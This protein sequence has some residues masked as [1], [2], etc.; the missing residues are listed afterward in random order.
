MS[1]GRHVLA[2]PFF[3]IAA[4]LLIDPFLTNPKRA[5]VAFGWVAIAALYL[6]HFWTRFAR[7]AW[8]G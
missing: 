8:I 1:L 6:I 4:A 7:V 3:F 2:T 5:R